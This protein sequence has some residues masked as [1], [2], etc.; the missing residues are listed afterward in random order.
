MRNYA[1][2]PDRAAQMADELVAL[3]PDVL[4]AMGPPGAHAA[5]RATTSV[6]VIFSSAGRPVQTGLVSNLVRPGGN[7]T[8]LSLDV[9]PE[10]N[11]K[12]LQIVRD[13]IG[14][15]TRISL[16]WNPNM[17]GINEYVDQVMQAARTYGIQLQSLPVRSADDL[18]RTFQAAAQTNSNA[19]VALADTMMM[20]HR[21]KVIALAAV[22]RLPAIF[23]FKEFPEA[24]GLMSYGPSLEAI[25]VRTADY[26]DKILRGA[27]PGDL[28]VEQP[29]IFELVI[30]LKTAKAL[31]LTIPPSLLLRADQ[32]IE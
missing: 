17:L 2:S 28:P 30:N 13:A 1:G 4:V 27:R 24:G 9:G 31:G 19:I 23:P 26:V 10:I 5:K 22:Y 7:V 18:E 25:Y 15:L 6:P 20:T 8:G 29:T 11:A 32:V 14:T 21:T 16:L 3:K 12:Q